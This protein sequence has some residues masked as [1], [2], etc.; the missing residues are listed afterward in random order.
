MFHV[1]ILSLRV[2]FTC[3]NFHCE[4]AC[5][6][7]ARMCILFREMERRRLAN[8]LLLKLLAHS[9]IVYSQSQV[10]EYFVPMSLKEDSLKEVE[11]VIVENSTVCSLKCMQ[12]DSDKD[13]LLVCPAFR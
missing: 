10:I 3:T 11:V 2:C 7:K 5:V 4:S 13:K 1:Y 9:F 8:L 12:N 6:S